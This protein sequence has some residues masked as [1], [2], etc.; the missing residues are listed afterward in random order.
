MVRTTKARGQV[1]K[2]QIGAQA[3]WLGSKTYKAE[4]EL[5]YG[6]KGEHRAW[7]KAVAQSKINV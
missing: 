5:S 3:A 7:N 6:I 2:A 4:Q 1:W